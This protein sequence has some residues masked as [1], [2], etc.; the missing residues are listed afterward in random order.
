MF[1]SNLVFAS[2]DSRFFFIVNVNRQCYIFSES[3]HSDLRYDILIILYNWKTK[4]EEKKKEKKMKKKKMKNRAKNYK[5]T[6]NVISCYMII[7][8]LVVNCKKY[9]YKTVHKITIPVINPH[10][11]YPAQ[12]IR[13]FPVTLPRK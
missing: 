9:T 8:L 13:H 11:T 4:N 3:S 10:A 7:L 12:I 2:K 1:H 5:I 6:L